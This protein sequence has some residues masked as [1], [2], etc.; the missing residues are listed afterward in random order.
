MRM[1]A[2]VSRLDTSDDQMIDDDDDFW[3]DFDGKKKLLKFW[4]IS[5]SYLF[6]QICPNIQKDIRDILAWA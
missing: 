3:Y 4:H 1:S 5:G 2:R 6:W